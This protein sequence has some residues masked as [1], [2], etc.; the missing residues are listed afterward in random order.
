[1]NGVTQPD[2]PPSIFVMFGR[3]TVVVG[4][5]GVPHADADAFR[6]AVTVDA[7]AAGR[8]LAP[9]VSASTQTSMAPTFLTATSIGEGREGWPFLFGSSFGGPGRRHHVGGPKS[10]GCR[11]HECHGVTSR[12]RTQVV[13]VLCV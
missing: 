12:V 2:G 11:D 10:A 13:W 3:N 8:A 5:P 1:M 9:S 6:E 7:A 4:V